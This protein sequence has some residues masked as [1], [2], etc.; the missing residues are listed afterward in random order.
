MGYFITPRKCS[1]DDVKCCVEFN[2]MGVGIINKRN[3]SV[4]I[5]LFQNTT[6][7]N[8]TNLLIPL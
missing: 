3:K 8:K 6:Y 4:K 1:F 5:I 7:L 2:V